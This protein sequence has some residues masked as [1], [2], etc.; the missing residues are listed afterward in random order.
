MEKIIVD[1]DAS[2]LRLDKFLKNRHKGLPQGLLQKWARK[3]NLSLNEKRC[4]VDVRVAE[5]DII[6]LPSYQPR[7]TPVSAIKKEIPSGFLRQFKQWIVFEDED[8]FIINKPAGLAVQ[9][10]SKQTLHL[11]LIL[12]ALANAGDQRPHLVHRLDKDTSGLLIIAKNRTS[13]TYLTNLFRDKQVSKTYLAIVVGTPKK[14][15]GIIDLPLSKSM[16][17]SGERVI[18]DAPDARS[19][20]TK[21]SI[22]ES[23][24]SLSLLSLEPLTGRTHQLRAHCQYSLNTPILGD[25]K[26][27]GKGAHPFGREDHMYLHS[28]KLSLLLQTGQPLEITSS[29]PVHFLKHINDFTANS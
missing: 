26:Y 4:K 8:L 28:Y 15:K 24:D 6:S 18:T 9:G 19:A 11:D 20:I 17:T 2:G 7:E 3:G 27:G 23:F 29:F 16:T 10:G 1:K 13:A 25:G 22:V 14:S 12:D 5:N 21:Y